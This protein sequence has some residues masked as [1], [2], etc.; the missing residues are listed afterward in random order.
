[1]PILY[2]Q[3]CANK[4][5]SLRRCHSMT[6]SPFD[7]DHKSDHRGHSFSKRGPE[8]SVQGGQRWSRPLALQHRHLLTDGHN[9]NVEVATRSE[10][11]GV[12][13]HWSRSAQDGMSEN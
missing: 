4:G 6:V 8:E 1:M 10:E 3:S 12:G 5:G 2:V 11:D 13:R 9:F 7:D